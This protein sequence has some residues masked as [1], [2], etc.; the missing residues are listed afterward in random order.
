MMNERRYQAEIERL[1]SPERLERL[2]VARVVDA[3]LEGIKPQSVLDVGTGSGVFAEAF[4]GRGLAVSG[5]DIN[6]AMI[7]AAQGFVPSAHFQT[8][9]AEALPFADKS[10]DLVYIGLVLHETDDLA[11]ALAEAH[12]V[13]RDRVAAQEWPYR[14]ETFGPPLAH[15][16]QP[17]TVE[18]LARQVGFTTFESLAL[19]QT[20]LFRLGG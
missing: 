12:R 5:I 17:Q 18:T 7:E 9:P 3:C 1:R 19:S 14:E 20:V 6:P 2:E 15:R 16:L 8:A 13:V 10:F 11:K 4:A